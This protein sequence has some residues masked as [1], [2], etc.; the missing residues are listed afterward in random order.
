MGGKHRILGQ[1]SGS[2]PFPDSYP[3]SPTMSNLKEPGIKSVKEV[4]KY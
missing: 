2:H 4:D 3:D 1:E